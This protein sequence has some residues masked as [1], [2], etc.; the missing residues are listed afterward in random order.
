MV[1]P[2][3][4][5]IVLLIAPVVI[6]TVGHSPHASGANTITV[7][8][9]LDPGT[10]GDHLCGLREAISIALLGYVWA[11]LHFLRARRTLL[12]DWVG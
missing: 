4:L 11:G 9:L 8:S 1:R 5:A 3:V 10:T 12:R 2:S 7:N 6:L